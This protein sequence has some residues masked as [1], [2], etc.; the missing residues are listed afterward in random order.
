[1]HPLGV[2]AQSN[3][4]P[5]P[6]GVPSLGLPL[7][8]GP[9][10]ANFQWSHVLQWIDWQHGMRLPADMLRLRLFGSPSVEGAEGRPLEGA[11]RQRRV[12][13]LLALLASGRHRGVSRDRVLALLWSEGEPEKARQALTQSLYHARKALAA[14]DLILAAA[15][16][17]LNPAVIKAD[18]IDFDEAFER[19][20]FTAA[21]RLYEG[22]YLDGF[23]VNGA[24]E[25]E[26][27]A[28]EERSRLRS[29][30]SEALEKLAS[31]AVERGEYGEAAE[32]RRQLAA[33]DPLNS[34]VALDLM[35]ALAAAGDRAG[36]IK[37]AQLHQEILREELG[38]SANPAILEFAHQLR[39][40]PLWTPGPIIVPN[41]GAP[42]E[43]M[44]PLVSNGVAP[45]GRWRSRRAA[46]VAAAVVVGVSLTSLFFVRGAGTRL[47]AQQNLTVVIPFRVAGADPAL[48]YLREGL[49]DLLV[50]KLIDDTESPAADAGAVMTAWREAGYSDR[51][52]V[53]QNA[54]VRIARQLGGSRLLIGSVVGTPSSLVINATLLSVPDGSL[55]AQASAGGPSDSLTIILDRLV[56]RLLAKE[57]GEWERLANRTSTSVFALRAFLDGQAAYRRGLYRDAVRHFRNALERD[58]AFAMAGLALANA[59]ERLNSPDDRARG[60]AA[61]WMAR[62]ELAQRDSVFLAALVGPHYPREASA[63]EQLSGWERAAT[64]TPERSEVWHKLGE[65]HFFDGRM[66]GLGDWSAR[67]YAAFRRSADLD[68]EF[69]SPLQYLV[70]L[71]AANAD[72]AGVRLAATAYLR[73]DSVGDLAAFVRWR[74]ATARADSAAL[75]SMRPRFATF[76][77]TSLRMIAL[78]SLYNATHVADGE[79]AVA[80]LLQRAARGSDRADALLARHAVALNTG[81]TDAALNALQALAEDATRTSLA[82]RL[83][84]LDAVYGDGDRAAAEA[85]VQRLQRAHQRDSLRAGMVLSPNDSQELCVLAQWD[86]WTQESPSMPKPPPLDSLSV[87]GHLCLSLIRAIRAARAATPDATQS[88]AQ[89]DSLRAVMPRDDDFH[90]YGGLALARLYTSV[91]DPRR[92]LD[93]VRRR[94]HMRPWP[95]YLASHL[96]EEGRLAA[97]I[98]DSAAARNAWLQYLSLRGGAGRALRDQSDSVRAML[99]EFADPKVRPRD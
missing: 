6:L 97:A 17:R 57:A 42:V 60:L 86:A 5:A 79:R 32:W 35:R 55:R 31:S 34:R 99:R 40:T 65:R 26:R 33:L 18:V 94:P 74:A 7:A 89:F 58:G 37:H 39:D 14:E 8:A 72:T 54:A 11:A 56:A 93:A 84:I 87:P 90:E 22:P 49:V 25:F 28:S 30:Y 52:D 64:V 20:D 48:G 68:P 70:Q 61:A 83:R 43:R 80:G 51:Q 29:R 24:P 12:L 46:W 96:M 27:W 36:A 67:A 47:A 92:A 4:V 38:A 98:Q 9:S 91:S 75:R 88:I 10:A 15:D 21:V 13:A 59:A 69:A 23:Y 73:I 66:L 62:A 78:S 71:T 82:L 3:A 63:R 1:D 85:A 81:S 2:F 50:A 53:P 44:A 19:G 41:V 45:E 95:R 77:A 16:L 76:P